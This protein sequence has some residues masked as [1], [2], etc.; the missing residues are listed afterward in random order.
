MDFSSIFGEAEALLP[1]FLE[2]LKG[3]RKNLDISI[4]LNPTN[5]YE[6]NWYNI[7]M[8]TQKEILKILRNIKKR[9]EEEGIEIYALFG[10][11]AKNSFDKF[12]DIDIA[13][14]IDYQ[15][16][17]QK[18][19]DGFSKLLRLQEIKEELEKVLQKKVDFVPFKN[20]EESIRV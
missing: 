17:S 16:F 7:H 13:Y 12:S 18:Y 10:S 14:K 6:K 8:K 11:Y 3:F 15:K 19:K 9:Y 5:S 4:C 2:I 1:E 20:F